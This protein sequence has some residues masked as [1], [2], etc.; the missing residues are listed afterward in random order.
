MKN[1]TLFFLRLF[2][3]VLTLTIGLGTISKAQ[4]II[5]Y[6]DFEK[7]FPG[8]YLLIDVDQQT[9]VLPEYTDAW[10]VGVAEDEVTN[11]SAL[12]TSWYDPAGQSDDWMITDTIF[13][14]DIPGDIKL[15]W[16]AH[17]LDNNY[18]D[19]YEV[20]ISNTTKDIAGCMANAPLFTIAEESSTITKRIVDLSAYKGDTIFLAFRNNSDDKYILSIDEITVYESLPYDLLINTANIPVLIEYTQIPVGQIGEGYPVQVSVRNEGESDPTSVKVVAKFYNANTMALVYADSII[21]A[22]APTTQNSE[23][24][25]LPS[26]FSPVQGITQYLGQVVIS[27]PE[28]DGNLDNNVLEGMLSLATISDS[29]YARDVDDDEA[30]SLSIGNGATG[31]LGQLFHVQVKDTLT[32]ITVKLREAV[33]GNDR[34]ISVSV[35]SFDGTTPGTNPLKKSQPI[36]AN[37]AG[38]YTLPLEGGLVLDPGEYLIG[39]NELDSSVTVGITFDIFSAGKS[40]FKTPVIQ[41]NNWILADDFGYF[42]TYMIRANFGEVVTTTTGL[43]NQLLEANISVYPNPTDGN[44]TLIIDHNQVS[45]YVVSVHDALGREVKRLD[46]KNILSQAINLDLSNEANGMY[47][48]KVQSGNRTTTQKVFLNR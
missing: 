10:I 44:C 13:M 12:S 34:N 5:Y 42:I 25:E 30:F 22:V 17:Q 24:Y 27:I 33:S 39:I 9:P 20:R 36:V 38:V 26:L 43:S 11:N 15:S 14:P 16:K 28:K 35:Y 2:T 8:N 1:F 7:G 48:I 31:V 6:E 21:N 46:L 23:M 32:S 3:T 4:N 19:G 37:E 47:F 41:Q 45:N 40:W 18:P 29:T